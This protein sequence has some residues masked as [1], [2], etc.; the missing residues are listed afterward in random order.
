MSCIT[1]KFIITLYCFKHI[2]LC[3]TTDFVF[4]VLTA[5]KLED[6]CPV[7]M[8]HRRQEMVLIIVAPWSCVLLL[9]LVWCCLL[10]MAGDWILW[11]YVWCW[12]AE[13]GVCD[14]IIHTISHKAHHLPQHYNWLSNPPLP[15]QLHV[16]ALHP[17]MWLFDN[18]TISQCFV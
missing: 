2:F 10:V 8:S 18:G 15:G 9:A 13:W 3:G 14:V 7:S 5:R 12:A 1:T 4:C 17:A 11:F 6:Y 16:K